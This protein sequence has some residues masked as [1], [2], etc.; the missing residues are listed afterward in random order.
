MLKALKPSDLSNM[1]GGE[2]NKNKQKKT[3]AFTTEQHLKQNY[4]TA[5]LT[6]T[7]G[8]SDVLTLVMQI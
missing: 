4:L 1:T 3:L 8:P 2:K 5:S 6:T 7:S